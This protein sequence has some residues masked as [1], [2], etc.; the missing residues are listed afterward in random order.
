LRLS[1]FGGALKHQARRGEITIVRA[2]KGI[3]RRSST[4][5]TVCCS[6]REGGEQHK[7][8]S[9]NGLKHRGPFMIYFAYRMR[10]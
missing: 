3:A 6:G 7:S 9:A 1:G 10:F 5:R 4:L 2:N 8:R